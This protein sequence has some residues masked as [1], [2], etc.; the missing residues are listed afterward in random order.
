MSILDQL[1]QIISRDVVGSVLKSDT[2]AKAG[3]NAK[4]VAVLLAV[5]ALAT[6]TANYLS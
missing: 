3:K 1:K 4:L 5:A 6:A 2:P